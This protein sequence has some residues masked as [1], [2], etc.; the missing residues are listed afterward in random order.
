MRDSKASERSLPYVWPFPVDESESRPSGENVPYEEVVAAASSISGVVSDIDAQ[1]VAWLEG[2]LSDP[3]R[4]ARIVLAVYAGCPTRFE[5]L[6]RLLEIQGRAASR[7]EFRILPVTVATGA[8]ANCLTVVPRDGQN[9]VCLFGGTPNFG[10]SRYDPT[11]FNVA[12]RADLELIDEWYGW[13]DRTRIRAA[14]LT[15]RTTK[16]PSLIPATGSAEAANQWRDY[17][18]VC[19]DEEQEKETQQA[20]SSA[21]PVQ[22]IEA[23]IQTSVSNQPTR[24]STSA[25]SSVSRFVQLVARV[26]ILLK[27]GRLITAV[28]TGAVGPLDIPVSA[29]FFNQKSEDWNEFVVRHQS[30]RVSAFT[31]DEQRQID[32]FRNRSRI[33]MN[34]LGLPF[35]RALRWMPHKMIPIFKKELSAVEKEAGALINQLVRS[36]PKTFIERRRMQIEESLKRT[37]KEFRGKGDL[38]PNKLNEVLDQLEK[39]IQKALDSGIV[40]PVSFLDVAIDLQRPQAH[41]DPWKQVETLIL[42]LARFPRQNI[43]RPKLFPKLTTE[44][45]LIND[46]MNVQDD[47]IVTL[48][49]ADLVQATRR[50]KRELGLLDRIVNSDLAVTDRC[51]VS[52]MIIDGKSDTEIYRLLNT[53]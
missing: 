2:L 36:N 9:P 15:E 34:I 13:F 35:E 38:P 17:C 25:S 30:F 12:F 14:P 48:N 32:A 41:E 43:V 44:P 39:K 8:P 10:I 23:S 26:T 53:L 7:I 28:S 16:I 27:K 3:K 42:A 49:E 5:H 33:V 1:G 22:N 31:E 21:T 37:Y 11:Q 24:Q 46:A 45:A 52:L 47:A 18:K 19:A 40:T 51:M 29:R 20:E 4:E 50:A 6:T